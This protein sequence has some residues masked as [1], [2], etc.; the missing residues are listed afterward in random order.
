MFVK[1]SRSGGTTFGAALPPGRSPSRLLLVGCGFDLWRTSNFS[2]FNKLQVSF[3]NE[4][5]TSELCSRKLSIN[6]H[7]AYPASGHSQF[8]RR[9]L[10]GKESLHIVSLLIINT[11]AHASIC[12]TEP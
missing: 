1:C 11:S 9:L 8:L 5:V 12:L 2:I 7:L 3:L 4:I 10:R 6:D